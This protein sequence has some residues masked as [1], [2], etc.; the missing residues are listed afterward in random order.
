MTVL[1]K[2]VSNLAKALNTL[3]AK[4]EHRLDEHAASGEDMDAVRGQAKTARLHTEEAAEDLSEIIMELKTLTQTT[5][6]GAKG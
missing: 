3:E 5:Q 2:A 6:P 4:L 1:E